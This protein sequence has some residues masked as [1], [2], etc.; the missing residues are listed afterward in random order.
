MINLNCAG[1]L[2]LQDEL[3]RLLCSKAMDFRYKIYDVADEP[4]VLRLLEI[5]EAD[6]CQIGRS[7][8]GKS[9]YMLGAIYSGPQ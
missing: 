1:R 6:A 9:L 7:Y 5:S 3:R 8:V 2:R 4:Y